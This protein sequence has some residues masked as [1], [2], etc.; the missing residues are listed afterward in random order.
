MK[1]A[2]AD[3]KS[4]EPGEWSPKVKVWAK[5]YPRE[6]H[7]PAVL[8]IGIALYDRCARKTTV[9]DLLTPAALNTI[10]E[11]FKAAGKHAPDFDNAVVELDLV[12]ELP[13]EWR[14]RVI[15]ANSKK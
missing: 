14:A 5:N 10:L 13:E 2:R 6:S 12:D 8:I 11:G 3:C 4:G 9:K 7:D 1:C 15:A